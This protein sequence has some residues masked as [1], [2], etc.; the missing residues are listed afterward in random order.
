MKVNC[1][2]ILIRAAAELGSSPARLRGRMSNVKFG[3][4]RPELRLTC[5]S[6]EKL[7]AVCGSVV[8]ASTQYTDVCV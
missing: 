1:E 2:Q 7:E 5:E 8:N 6:G 4:A 3:R